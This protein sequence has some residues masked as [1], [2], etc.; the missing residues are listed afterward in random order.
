M[1][2]SWRLALVA[3]VAFAAAMAGTYAARTLSEPPRRSEGE[4]HA[5]LH[6]DVQLSSQQEA[7]I[8][9]IEARYAVRKKALELDLRAANA[10]LAEA[11]A[12]EKGYGPQVTAAVDNVH[13]VMGMMQ[14]DT[15]EHL[16]AMRGVLNAE[17]ARRFDRFVVKALTT[18]RR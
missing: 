2:S 12:A 13:Q 9:T 3:L 11:I 18:E 8:E 1:R 5:F 15:L 6:D 16:F 14:K 17:Q 7:A 10:R 4:L